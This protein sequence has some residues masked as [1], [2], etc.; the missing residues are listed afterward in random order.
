MSFQNVP[1]RSVDIRFPFMIF[2]VQLRT[3]FLKRT[4]IIHT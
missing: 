4:L 2:L 3:I 1:S